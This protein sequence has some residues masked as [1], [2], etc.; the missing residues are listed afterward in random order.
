MPR[1]P[2]EWD[3]AR[4]LNS[5]AATLL[6]APLADYSDSMA[7]SFA[8]DRRVLPDPAALRPVGDKIALELMVRGRLRVREAP[9]AFADRGDGPSKLGWQQRLDY[10]HDLGQLYAHVDGRALRGAAARR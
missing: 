2:D 4:A 5:R 9:I 3:R 10:L 8:V 1:P 6:A 7:V